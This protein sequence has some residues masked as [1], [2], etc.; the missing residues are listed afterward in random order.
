MLGSVISLRIVYL[1]VNSNE[2]QSSRENY[3][4]V[5]CANKLF[6]A[7]NLGPVRSLRQEI[8]W[9]NGKHFT[10]SHMFG[11]GYCSCKVVLPSHLSSKN[12][13]C[14]PSLTTNDLKRWK[15][16]LTFMREDKK[17]ESP[18]Y[19]STC[20]RGLEPRYCLRGFSLLPS[21]IYGEEFKQLFAKQ[22]NI[23][24]VQTIN[25]KASLVSRL[26]QNG[27]LS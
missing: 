12:L 26:T 1:G 18:L 24:N 21:P 19:N 13:T 3:M 25:S 17:W 5:M 10:Y 7:T 16:R 22:S 15:S 23:F 11:L 9:E 20:T 2:K 4:L 27:A 6:Q 14:G 8:W